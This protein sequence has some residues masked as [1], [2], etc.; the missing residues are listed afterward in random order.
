MSPDAFVFTSM[1]LTHGAAIGF[2]VWELVRLRRYRD[3]GDDRD[4]R[5]PPVPAPRPKGGEPVR[6][7]LPACLIPAPPSPAPVRILEDA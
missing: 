7:P 4:R 1:T 5:P 6:K 2:A 3:A